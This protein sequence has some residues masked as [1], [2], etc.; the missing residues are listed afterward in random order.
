MATSISFSPTFGAILLGAQAAGIG[1]NIY[2][3]RQQARAER[4]G[5]D[6]DEGNMKLRMQQEQI[7]FSQQNIADLT[8]L[9]ETLAAQRAATSAR[10]QL[11]G[12]GSVLAV[13][14][15]SIANFN[16]DRS[17]RA[18][19]VSFREDYM[20]GMMGLSRAALGASKAQRGGN[21][22]AQGANMFSVN[23]LSALFQNVPIS[24]GS[25]LSKNLSKP[26]NF[27]ANSLGFK[28]GRI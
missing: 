2:S 25:I 17:A 12:A 8:N 19:N 4:A 21:L 14:N 10:G 13:T 7:A 5:A 11:P 27:G 3:S 1:A 24:E 16:A 9:R 28:A 6:I 23:T 18:L 15:K 26:T 22:M 20:K